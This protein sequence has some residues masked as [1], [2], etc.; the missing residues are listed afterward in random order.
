[1]EENYKTNTGK[2]NIDQAAADQ[3]RDQAWGQLLNEQLLNKQYEKVGIT[4]SP[5]EIFDMVQGK[6]PHQQIKDAFKDPKTGQ[7]NPANVIQFL[8][9][10]DNDQT[11]KTRAQWLAFENFL[12]EDR[13]TQKFNNLVKQGLYVTTEEAKRDYDAKGKQAAIKYVKLDYATIS[14]STVKPSESDLKEYYNENQNKYKQEASRKVEYVIFEVNPSD[15]DRKES[16]DY[17][18][19]LVESFK[20]STDDSSFVKNNADSKLD[21]MFH[22]KGTL[23]PIM[24]T[25]FFNA[26]VGT[27]VGPYEEN[28][29]FKISKLMAA[30]DIPDSIK[31]SH[32]LITYKG[33]QRAPE[34]VTRTKEEAKVRADSLFKIAEKDPKAFIEIA[35]GV[36]DDIVS[37]MK[38][39]DLGWINMN[40]GMDTR[41]KAGAFATDKGKVKLVESDF[42]FHIIKV[43][44]ISKTEKQVMVATVDRR[45]EAGTKTYQAI[46]TK[47][48]EFA[49]KNNTAEAFDKAVKDQGLNKR[50]AESLSEAEKNVPGLENA[51][52]MVRW[53]YRSEKGKI[54]EKPFEFGNKF[55]V[56]K[57]VEIREKGIAPLEQVNDQVTTEVIK[58]LKAKQLIEKM[59]GAMSGASSVD[60]VASKL[61]QPA[62]S[63]SNVNFGAPYIQN[64]GMEP[65]L[66]GTVFTLKPN[67]FSKPIKGETGVYAVQVESFT[68]APPMKDFTQNKKQMM[69]QLGGRASYEVFNALKEKADV[70]DNRG[71]F[72]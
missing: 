46:F 14:D 48:T 50:V 58:N 71:K 64:I 19:K 40:S 70:V 12:K 35:K 51:R 32:A 25:V 37:A 29:Y 17:I 3:L 27:V 72:Y 4:V 41:F 20:A 67:Q 31:V 61:G 39:G 1:M 59:N 65:A 30:K 56:A 28:G 53:A 69:Q 66:V 8:K 34:T 2:D 68:E 62:A 23:S 5:E 6:N 44:D 36:S 57:L 10:M 55:V 49:G 33:A 52:E 45:I 54:T 63:A 42:G 38:E 60:A 22:K 18:S 15:A 9:N 11:G 7:F 43:F 24:D 21:S 26:P 47:A 13:T 16:S